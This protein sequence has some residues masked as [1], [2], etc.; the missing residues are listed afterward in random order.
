MGNNIG[1]PIMENNGNTCGKY[2]LIHL[3]IVKRPEMKL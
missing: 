1:A 3:K 2:C